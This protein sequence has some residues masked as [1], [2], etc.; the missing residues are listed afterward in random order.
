MGAVMLGLLT[1]RIAAIV[2]GVSTLPSG[3]ECMTQ[4]GGRGDK[5]VLAELLWATPVCLLPL[6][7]LF[8]HLPCHVMIGTDFP[9]YLFPVSILGGFTYCRS[10][11]S[12]LYSSHWARLGDVTELGTDT[13]GQC[14]TVQNCLEE[15]QL[16]GDYDLGRK[17]ISYVH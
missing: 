4:N 5:F 8:P 3:Q 9:N 6:P 7:F 11:L 12:E 1:R 16:H 14:T 13:R 15:E 2:T 17:E 10:S